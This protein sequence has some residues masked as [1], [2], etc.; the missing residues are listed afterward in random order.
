M[1]PPSLRILSS[2]AFSFPLSPLIGWGKHSYG[3]HGDD[4]GVFLESRDLMSVDDY[5]DIPNK[6]TKALTP[7]EAF[8]EDWGM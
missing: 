4:G 7:E 6:G 2:S 3:F 5:E 8:L 1:D